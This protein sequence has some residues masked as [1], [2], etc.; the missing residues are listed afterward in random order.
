MELYFWGVRG[1]IPAP[2]A[3]TH[4]YGGNTSCL[5]IKSGRQRLIFDAGTGLRELGHKIHVRPG[6][7]L[8]IFLSHCHLDHMSGLPF[9]HPLHKRGVTVHLYGPHGK[10]RPLRQ[11][12]QSLFSEEFYPIPFNKLAATLRFH[13]L[14]KSQRKIGPFTI[15]SHPLN[16]P[17]STLGY[18]IATSNKRVGY[19]TDHEPIEGFRHVKGISSR[20]YET[21]LHQWLTGLDVL[22][23]DAQY[24]DRQYGQYRGWG[25]SPWHYVISLAEQIVAK[26]L[27]LFH[28]SPDNSDALLEKELI[29]VQKRLAKQKHRLRISLAKERKRYKL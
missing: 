16:H 2:G 12:I 18:V 8:H 20:Q 7:E 24:L 1:S 3:K 13:S 26:Q 22:I 5:E 23:H 6:T 15:T 9:F 29:R 21:N 28:H 17:G 27:I 10:Q 25:H 14:Q 19:V 11:I 4:R